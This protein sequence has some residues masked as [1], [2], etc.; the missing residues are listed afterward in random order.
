[1]F[2]KLTIN[3]GTW[4]NLE[5]P[6]GRHDLGVGAGD[7]DAGV[8]AGLVMC[9]DDI[10]AE[11]L[12]GAD[13]TV[14]WALWSRVT[15]YWPSIRPVGHV[16]KGILLLKTEP[17]LLVLVRLHEFRGLMTMVILV[18][19]SIWIPTFTENEDVWGAAHWVGEHGD[20]AEVNIRV[21]AGGLAR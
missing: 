19:G 8:Q 5:L 15:I 13:T 14:I 1:M 9:L 11:D 12:A 16:E 21:V 3:T 10:A 2:N 18:W 20:G 7:A 4:A 17:R 6:L